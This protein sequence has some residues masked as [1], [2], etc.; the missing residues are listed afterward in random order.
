MT[1]DSSGIWSVTLQGDYKNV[2]YTYLV[3]VS[4]TTNETQDV[5]SKATGVNGK[6]SMVV[7]LDAT[8]P[9]GWNTDK[10]VF[11]DTQTAS[12]VWEVHVRDF[13]VSSTYVYLR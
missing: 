2:Y 11:Q 12:V 3:T 13:S 1:K 10:H 9:D 6:R 4:G 7:D 8:D 5:Y